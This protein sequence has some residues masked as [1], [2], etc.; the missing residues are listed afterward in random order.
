MRTITARKAADVIDLDQHRAP[1]I[2]FTPKQ[3]K[4]PEFDPAAELARKRE[5]YLNGMATESGASHDDP[6][7]PAPVRLFDL[8]DKPGHPP[9]E[10]IAQDPI[11][12]QHL[13]SLAKRARSRVCFDLRKRANADAALSGKQKLVFLFLLDKANGAWRT[14]W[15]SEYYLAKTMS[16]SRNTVRGAIAKL[17]DLG[18]L[19]VQG[20]AQGRHGGRK[21]QALSFPSLD[22]RYFRRFGITR[23]TDETTC[24]YS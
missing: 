15:W 14:V 18:Y 16:I 2:H 19:E 22:D 23:L 1:V 13:D 6:A 7:T 9:G 17:I 10:Q 4:K 5:Q 8:I 24:L 20:Y 12:R 21:V 11:G 3:R